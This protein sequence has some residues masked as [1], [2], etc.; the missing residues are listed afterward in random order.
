MYILKHLRPASS[1]LYMLLVLVLLSGCAN[2]DA[3][4]AGHNVDGATSGS[5]LLASA[6]NY[7]AD[8]K[9]IPINYTP[10]VEMEAVKDDLGNVAG[11]HHDN[12]FSAAEKELLRKNLFLL[13]SGYNQSMYEVYESKYMPVFVSSDAVLHAYHQVFDSALMQS[14]KRFYEDLKM[15]SAGLCWESVKVYQN[16]KDEKLKEAAKLNIAYFGVAANLLGQPIE[17][18]VL[19]ANT[20][21]RPIKYASKSRLI[22]PI[23]IPAD[24]ARLIKAEVKLIEKHAGFSVSPIFGYEEDYS[25]FVPRGHYTK[26]DELKQYF[27]AMVWY[28]RMNFHLRIESPDSELAKRHTRQALLVARTI[29]TTMIPSIGPGKPWQAL[30]LWQNIYDPT[31]FFVGYSDDLNVR[32]YLVL[33]RKIYGEDPPDEKLAD[34][35]LLQKFI[36]EAL[37]LK[38]PKISS[39]GEGFSPEDEMG[40]KFMGQRFV[41]DSYIFQRL[42]FFETSRSMPRALDI[43]AVFGS[44]RAYEILDKEFKET[45]D[46]RYVK[47]VN[48]LKEEFSSFSENT[49]TQNLYWGWLYS[50]KSLLGERAG[51]YPPFMQSKAWQDKS[52]NTFLGSWT[53]LR[54]DTILYAKQSYSYR[55]ISGG[56]SEPID[57]YVEPNP[58]L[59]AR[60]LSLTRLTKEGLNERGLLATG[61]ELERRLDE[62]AELLKNCK[63]TSEK[64]LSGERISREENDYFKNLDKILKRF[65]YPLENPPESN[66]DE[67]NEDHDE[68]IADVHT[69]P[70]SNTCLEVA[71]GKPMEMFVIAPVDG[72]PVLFRGG[73]YSYYEFTKPVPERMNDE[74]WRQMVGGPDAPDRPSWTKSFSINSVH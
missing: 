18:A 55:G 59:Y 24:A 47:N 57:V 37:K 69:D 36:D 41:P 14:E 48:E 61:S 51:G 7:F 53:E 44:G 50:L 39:T 9:P 52:L 73:A 56:G 2:R 60:L 31:A 49:W 32:D 11:Y 68:L 3:G 38:A 63:S 74:E 42:V 4:R 5:V 20:S 46:E 26:S 54:H 27:K 10:S 67:W 12:S 6:R 65:Y 72:K 58:E 62:L 66:R 34:D 16:A 22:G 15:L 21:N 45:R 35:K 8:Y 25:Q 28:G 64:E 1:L 43:P 13:R 71:V 40:F 30:D 23:L 33:M 29:E 70:N 17:G 19:P